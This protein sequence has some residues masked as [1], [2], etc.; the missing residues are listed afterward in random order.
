MRYLMKQKVLALGDAF[1][2]QDDSGEEVY[3]VQGKLVSIG[4]RLHFRDMDGQEVALIKQEVITLRPSYRIFRDGKLQADVAKRVFAM[5]KDKFKVDM[6][7]GSPDLEIAGNIA[8]HEYTF[9][10]GDEEVARVSK[11]WVS[12]SDTYG[13]E[14]DEGEDDIL[15][16]ACVIIVDMI[17]HDHDILPK[18]RRR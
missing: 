6:K 16:L 4:D 1:T 8:D 10:R 5:L 17:S 13:I 11:N 12:F 9:L 7:D 15:I 18:R 3:Q 14:V 2:I